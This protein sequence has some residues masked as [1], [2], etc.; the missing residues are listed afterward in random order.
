M[1]FSQFNT[2]LVSDNNGNTTFGTNSSA[3]TNPNAPPST[4]GNLNNTAVGY[5]TLRVNNNGQHNIAIGLNALS[6]NEGNNNLAFGENALYSYTTNA[7]HSGSN[8]IAIGNNAINS[9]TSAN[10][11]ISIG[12]NTNANNKNNCILLGNGAITAEDSEIGLGG[13]NARETTNSGSQLVNK[14]LKTRLSNGT[15]GQGQYYIPLFTNL[16]DFTASTVAPS[17]TIPNG[18]N[19]GNSLLQTWHVR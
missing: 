16:Q 10:G 9:S 3:N 1:S 15:T 5:G 12:N 14:F 13:M 17:G 19:F 18:T 2:Q 6:N 8:N 7:P 11:T 4:T